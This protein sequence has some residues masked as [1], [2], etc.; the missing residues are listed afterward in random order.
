[1][2]C[3][4]CGA[5]NPDDAR[6]CSY[7]GAQLVEAVPPVEDL[8]KEEPTEVP[9]AEPV[10]P[11]SDAVSEPV[12][13]EPAAVEP[14]VEE[15]PFFEEPA[16]PRKP[17]FEE[18][19]W[20]VEEY[21][22]SFHV[23]KTDDINFDWNA[24]PNDIP[25]YTRPLRKS[26]IE[27]A[28]EEAPEI[29]TSAY[30]TP[31]TATRME[32]P[33]LGKFSFAETQPSDE[34]SA[35]ERIDK[36]YTFNRK[37]EEFQ[38]LLNQEYDKIKEGGAINDEISQAEQL[39]EEK[40]ENREEK[41][42]MEDFL[43]QEGVN[44][45]Y[46]PKAF[47][48]DILARIEAQEKAREAERI[49]EE[50]RKAAMEQARLEA[51]AQKE[52]EEA[53]RKAEEEAR[54][55]AEEE[56][57]LKAEEEARLK[58]EEE[59]RL[60]A[61]EEARLAA[62]EEARLKA[63]EE[64][65]L[66]A[67]EEARIAA[68]EEARRAEE[69]ARRKA[70]EEARIAAEE[71][72]ARLRAEEEARLAE[73]ARLKAEE[74]AR[75]AAE[76]EARRKAEEEARLAAEEEARLKAEEEARLKAEAEL[77]AAQEAAKIRAQ[78]EARIAAEEEAKKAAEAEK[79]EAEQAE[80]ERKDYLES[81]RV[82]RMATTVAAEEEARKILE[83]TAR[84]KEEE[85]AKIKAA[86]AGFRH[87]SAAVEEAHQA[88]K[89]QIDKMVK[90]RQTY[91]E[92]F[93]KAFAKAEEA[94]KPV[95]GR[96]TMLS[97]DDKSQTKVFVEG[98][99]VDRMDDTRRIS[100]EELKNKDDEQFFQALEER[101]D[102]PT[103]V[104]SVQP[105]AED[106]Y[107]SVEDLLKQFESLAVE[108]PA[109]E[110]AAPVEENLRPISVPLEDPNAD[111]IAAFFGELNP[112]IPPA[113]IVDAEPFEVPAE[114]QTAELDA[115]AEQV[116]EPVEEVAEA[117]EEPVEAPV[118]ILEPVSVNGDTPDAEEAVESVEEVATAD[119]VEDLL[120][121]LADATEETTVPSAED[122][123]AEAAA[124]PVEE[125]AEEAIPEPV[126]EAVEEAIPEPIEEVAYPESGFIVGREEPE[127]EAEEPTHE[128]PG[129][130]DTVV[131]AHPDDEDTTAAFAAN[132]F[133]NYGV[134]EAEE[135]KR[136]QE[137]LRQME[138]VQAVQEA[139]A[140]PAQPIAEVEDTAMDKAAAKAAAKAE[141][142]A[143][144]EAAKAAA[145]EEAGKS[146]GGAGRVILKILLILLIV[147]LVVELASI[148]VK[149]FM[150]ESA[151]AGV[152]DRFLDTI[153]GLIAG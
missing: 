41:L 85:E 22:D 9:A 45:P 130:A 25:D 74:E 117:I 94:Q 75:I 10:F 96:E 63:E 100:K 39:A 84:L 89:D 15:D 133:D 43:D 106:N 11:E 5:N 109:E 112:E 71:E 88:T 27:E 128:S 80:A 137:A 146:K 87:E 90:A 38:Q 78:Q 37:N 61:E 17:F 147:I 72:A 2:F 46:E 18:M 49:E 52:A 118:G 67:E 65:R 140:E 4:R 127:I 138:A 23:E 40:F 60:R 28:L 16:K 83:H 3:N 135:Y 56:A 142:K 151:L 30:D 24:D 64:A 149:I 77:K 70:E 57:R 150:P 58:A 144:K 101:I 50:A 126:E 124:E 91:F 47:E 8:I 86:I 116:E 111:P 105:Q 53:A 110:V 69:E 114:E 19:Q 48:S 36:F 33:D 62:E 66:R 99:P 31:I 120:A 82:S 95:T 68:E 134:A 97:A 129:L 44:K 21:P 132:D 20:D 55:K 122:E 141:K 104:A 73:E 119:S 125:A 98:R 42:T 143:A 107:S 29:D 123:L 79:L 152:I 145:R 115:F 102:E 54:L 139:P 148:G 6:F 131:M 35:A 113:P 93:D 76:E 13:E 14:V 81:E 12:I 103:V 32:A 51:V 34:P 108:E 92:D 7:C 59:A 1:M 26:Q 153:I 121:G 136:K